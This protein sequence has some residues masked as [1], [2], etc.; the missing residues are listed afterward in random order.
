M[1]KGGRGRLEWTIDQVS[2]MLLRRD[3]SGDW[4]KTTTIAPAPSL[5]VTTTSSGQFHSTPTFTPIIRVGGLYSLEPVG[6]SLSR[7]GF[8]MASIQTSRVLSCVPLFLK[9]LS[10]AH[11][12]SHVE[13][14]VKSLK[15]YKLFYYLSRISTRKLGA[16]F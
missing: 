14:V 12:T 15:F 6:G 3:Y 1:G 11:S 9:E 2:V 10:N 8:V 5:G 7:L 13:T 16:L 4:S